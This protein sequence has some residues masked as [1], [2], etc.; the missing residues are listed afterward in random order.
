MAGQLVYVGFVCLMANVVRTIPVFQPQATDL[1]S[2]VQL[3]KEVALE[4]F[5]SD[6]LYN[7]FRFDMR[8]GTDQ[9]TLPERIETDSLLVRTLLGK[10]DMVNK[11]D[12]DV[13]GDEISA[14][15]GSAFEKCLQE[16]VSRESSSRLSQDNMNSYSPADSDDK[17]VNTDLEKFLNSENISNTVKRTGSLALNPTGWR[18]RRSGPGDDERLQRFMRNMHELLQKRQRLQFNPTGW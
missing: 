11:D 12:S 9:L 2:T 14:A 6:R 13:N 17:I 7:D 3:C 4:T 5:L 18:K 16:Y 15:F 10:D 1:D 8:K